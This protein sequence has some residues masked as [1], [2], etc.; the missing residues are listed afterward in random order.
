MFYHRS[1]RQTYFKYSIFQKHFSNFQ[2]N[3]FYGQKHAVARQTQGILFRITFAT[4]SIISPNRID[5]IISPVWKMTQLEKK[6]KIPSW[7]LV[8]NEFAN[9]TAG[10]RIR[11]F[12]LSLTP[13]R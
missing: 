3:C 1:T 6:D 8:S 12:L 13:T 7:H 4:F 2:S 11:N 10:S 9:D 5:Q